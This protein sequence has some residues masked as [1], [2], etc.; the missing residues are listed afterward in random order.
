[1]TFPRLGVRLMVGA[2]LLALCLPALAIVPHEP[3]LAPGGQELLATV[4]VATVVTSPAET[5]AWAARDPGWQAFLAANPGRWYPRHDRR[6]DRLSFAWGEGITWLPFDQRVSTAAD[7]AKVLDE[8]ESKARAF[9][10]ANAGLYRIPMGMTFR[11]DASRS[12]EIDAGRVWYLRLQGFVGDVPVDGSVLTFNLNHGRLVQ[13]GIGAITDSLG[14]APRAPVLSS[15]AAA[16]LGRAAIGK[17]LGLGDA[18]AK[19]EDRGDAR[20]FLLPWSSDAHSYIGEP[21]KGYA[22]RLCWEQRLSVPG[23]RENWVVVHD[24]ITGERLALFD[25][26]KYACTP[27]TS[28]QGRVVG[29]VFLG[30]IED[31]PETIIGMPFTSVTNGA[32]IVTDYNGIFPFTVG[33]PAS[34]TLSGAFFDMDCQGCTTPQQ[35]LTTSLGW[36]NLSLG[37]GGDNATGNGLSTKA[38]R[39]CFY[40]LNK[41]RQLA[42]A[43]ITDAQAGGF[44]SRSTP[45][46]VN[47]NSNCNAFW[48]G[49]SVNF[50]R[51]GGGC[52]NTGEIA[53]VMQHEW[54]HGLDQFTGGGNDGARGEGFSDVVAFLSTHDP[55]LG[56]Y[57][58]GGDPS[59]IR[60]AD[61]A[62]GLYSVATVG[63]LCPGGGGGS[64]PL[65]FEVHCEGIIHSQCWWHLAATSG[66]GGGA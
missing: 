32:N 28:P 14:A 21:G 41:V 34:T 33:Q 11:R 1:M 30:P 3:A 52:N 49:N 56:P 62:T 64:G 50:F 55:R 63:G 7:R 51:A 54:G 15:S 18:A 25:F 53:D 57:F 24:A 60:N 44:L 35:A 17:A 10:A 48:D 59:G 19:I 22:A 37:V 5:A 39:N 36:G 66:T 31:V 29:G 16:D 6:S 42:A 38:E 8:V 23:A 65:G 40:H 46:N 45:A 27:P 20:L 43:H 61:E 4:P 9:M 2:A 58:F 47:I 12:G 26:N 13:L